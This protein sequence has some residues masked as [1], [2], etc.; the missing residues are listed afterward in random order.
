MKMIRYFKMQKEKSSMKS[1]IWFAHSA[2]LSHTHVHSIYR[3]LESEAP[4]ELLA[5]GRSG[6]TY[7]KRP[8]TAAGSLQR[9]SVVPDLM[10][11]EDSNT[12][13]L[14]QTD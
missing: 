3:H 12:S 6:A 13:G 4:R 10:P 5:L 2:E 1:L 7:Q 11:T 8:C 9:R 14:A